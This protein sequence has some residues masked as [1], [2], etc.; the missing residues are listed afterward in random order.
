LNLLRL[1]YR[2]VG[3]NR[4]S[5]PWGAVKALALTE[6]VEFSYFQ[7]A[8]KVKFYKLSKVGLTKTIPP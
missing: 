2:K 5:S 1:D 8:Q 3:N 4:L 7:L 6:G